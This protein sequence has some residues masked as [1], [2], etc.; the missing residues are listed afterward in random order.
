MTNY[1][2]LCSAAEFDQLKVRPEELS[3]IG[4]N[5][6][7]QLITLVTTNEQISLKSTLR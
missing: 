1:T 7:M 4:T 5:L 3:E 6:P 2:V